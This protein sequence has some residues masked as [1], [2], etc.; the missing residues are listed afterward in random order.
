VRIAIAALVVFLA[1]CT[2]GDTRPSIPSLLPQSFAPYGIEF[3]RYR[4]PEFPPQLR[5]TGVAS[6][7]SVIAVT[8][9]PSGRVEDAVG[10]EASDQAFIDAVLA[11]T[12]EWLLAPLST[13]AATE[14]RREVLHYQFR[15]SGVVNVLTHRE[16]AE[17]A[18]PGSG[19][20]VARVRTV[21]WSDMDPPPER[22]PPEADAPPG[23]VKGMAEINFIIDQ[24]GR[25]RVPAIVDASDWD[26]ALVAL[27]AVRSWRF[28]PPQQDGQPVLVDVRARWG[29]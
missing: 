26:A 9:E 22:L 20:G 12:P 17:S 7:Y 16:G 5:A 24:T 27:D 11:V 18:F 1:A 23:R 2:R 28:A 14:P 10:M 3:V 21:R 13:A 6:G 4:A 15:L 8:V 19:D 25:V 29:D